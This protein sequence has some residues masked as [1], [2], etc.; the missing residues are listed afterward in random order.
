VAPANS[1]LHFIAGDLEIRD[2]GSSTGHDLSLA[3]FTEAGSKI[4][5]VT[6]G[7][8]YAIVVR[9]SRRNCR[10][11]ET[12][13][14]RTP[15]RTVAG[16]VDAVTCVPRSAEDFETPEVFARLSFEPS[17]RPAPG[18]LPPHRGCNTAGSNLKPA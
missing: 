14:S 10:V 17:G 3:A 8:C 16:R 18:R 4:G 7:F 6:L 15:Q 1:F 9:P 5:I 13:V 2:L 11:P 12:S